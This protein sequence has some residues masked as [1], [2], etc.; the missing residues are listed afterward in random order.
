VERLS[1]KP[2]GDALRTLMSECDLSYRSLAV[3][4]RLLD[5]KGMTHTR[6]RY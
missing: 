6:A 2:F 3:R 5:G 1:D 4:T